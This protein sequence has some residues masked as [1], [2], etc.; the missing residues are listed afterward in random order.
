MSAFQ[1]AKRQKTSSLSEEEELVSFTTTSESFSPAYDLSGKSKG[2]AQCS[3]NGHFCFFCEYAETPVE[4]GDAVGQ[5]KAMARE[6]A[7]A[8]KE[9]P[10]IVN[11]VYRAYE[12]GVRQSVEWVQA[13]GNVV[14]APVWTPESIKRHLVY[15]N[16]F[17]G[18]F[19]DTVDRIFQSLITRL[20]DSAID[21]ESGLV[22]EDHRRA[23]VE[24][25]QRYASWEKHT[26][27]LASKK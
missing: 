12:S 11:A 20:N 24:T 13:N 1:N 19:R 22:H 3:A 26:H 15:S 27:S 9:L 10:V 7:F 2:G 5:L 16:E 17:T 25:I 18:L 6:L 21:A 8:K 4:G 14:T 23:L